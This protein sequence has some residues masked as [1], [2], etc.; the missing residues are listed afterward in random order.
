M[1]ID[2]PQWSAAD[3]NVPPSMPPHYPPPPG[4]PPGYP[5]QPGWGAP[6]PPPAMGY[7][8]YLVARPAPRKSWYVVAAVLIVLGVIAGVGAGLTGLQIM[9]NQPRGQ[10]SFGSGGSATVH[11]DSGATKIIYV[12]D[13]GTGAVHRIHCEVAPVQ[14]LQFTRYGRNLA[15]GEWTAYFK[16]TAGQSGD[17]LVSCIG[18]ASDRFGVG[19]DVGHGALVAAV[20]GGLGSAALFVLGIVTLVVTAVLRRRRLQQWAWPGQLRN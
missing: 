18:S 2:P 17:Y 5:G 8:P 11:I 3:P 7:P 15:L 19:D 1:S 13:A 12:A 4:Y 16:I 9:G 10:D 20:V 14:G 6:V